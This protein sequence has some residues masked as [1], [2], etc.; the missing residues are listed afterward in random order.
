MALP[1]S[2]PPIA[3]K[4]LDAGGL[5]SNVWIQIWTNWWTSI[6]APANV[7]A[8]PFNSLATGVIGQI[9]FDQNFLYVAVGT[10]KWKRLPLTNF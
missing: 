2:P 5:F 10:N 6:R 9:A 3:T 4:V 1:V 8:P 7:T